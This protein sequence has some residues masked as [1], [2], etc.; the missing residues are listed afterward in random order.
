MIQLRLQAA[1]EQRAQDHLADAITFSS[2]R[3][4]FVADERA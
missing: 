1:R 4:V 3:M 2:G